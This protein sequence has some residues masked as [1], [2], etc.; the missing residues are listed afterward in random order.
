VSNEAEVRIR[1]RI[2]TGELERRWKAVRQAMKES[3]L[4]YLVFHNCTDILGGYVKWFTDMPAVLNYPATVLF[5]IDDEMTTIWHGPQLPAEPGPPS[6]AVR[7]VKKRISYPFLPSLAYTATFD[8]EKVTEEL[9]PHKDC[10]IGLVGMG[11]I[12]AA[13]YKYVTEHLSTAK[14]TDA[15]DLVDNIK[16]IKSDE[17][18]KLIRE[19]AAMQDKAFEY[20][21]TCIKPGRRDRD[22]SAD[23][24]HKCLELGS[25]Q[26]NMMLG[27]APP[28]APARNLLMHFGNRM[29]Q[30][31][32]Q[33][34]IL[35]ESNGPSGF[36]TEIGRTIC[37]GKAPPEL[38]ENVELSKKAQKITVDLLKPGADPVSIWNANNDF[39]KSVG[40]PAETRIYAHGM[41]YDMVE[42]PSIM[43]GETMKIQARMSLAV[44]PTVA[45]AKA[46]G[47]VCD[48]FL[49]KEKG[50]P[51]RLH[52]TAQKVFVI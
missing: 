20:A 10:R 40:F 17:E 32:D 43:P 2:S 7:G 13:F 49:V 35:I 27:S 44:H 15:T 23:V 51:E 24:F 18:I 52:K 16:A 50:A 11:F 4:D 28:G 19:I 9:A 29:I 12:P 33:V 41:G 47:Q 5:P 14:F 25:E 8:A 30:E 42:R 46:M 22:V 6:W 26:A 48:N 1:S 31:G 3:K 45:S 34:Y 39:M 37:L 38:E 21:L 36:Y